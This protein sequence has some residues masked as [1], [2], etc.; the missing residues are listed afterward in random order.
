[1]ALVVNPAGETQQLNLPFTE[2][3]GQVIRRYFSDDHRVVL[4]KTNATPANVLAGLKGKSFWHFASHGA[5]DWDR[6]NNSGLIM[7]SG[8]RL[9]IAQLLEPGAALGHPR[10]VVLSA[11]ETGLYDL[12]SEPLAFQGMPGAFL[13]LGASGVIAS[14]WQVDDIAT[15]LLMVRF[16]EELLKNGQRPAS[17]LK[18]AQ[19]WLRNAT[20]NEIVAYARTN[21]AGTEVS[22]VIMQGIEAAAIRS[23][24]SGGSRNATIWRTVQT[25]SEQ[26]ATGNLSQ[27]KPFAHPYYW[28][29]FV[30]T[31]L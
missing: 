27:R 19:T 20:G 15:S 30:L 13:R 28:S 17:A 2:L 3:E 1:M 14:L 8:Q 24:R 7:R 25:R 12:Q 16:Y 11:C 10:L 22:P 4:D 23:Q 29:G 21:T 31:G 18:A 6:P 26:G 9:T 5:F